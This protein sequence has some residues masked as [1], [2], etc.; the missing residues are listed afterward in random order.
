MDRYLILLIVRG[1]LPTIL[2]ISSALANPW[3][4]AVKAAKHEVKIISP[5]L[6]S[7]RL[8]RQFETNPKI[9]YQ[10]IINPDSLNN[11]R[12]IIEDLP[13]N[14]SLK[15]L[16]SPSYI[17]HSIMLVDSCKL[18]FG[19]SQPSDDDKLNFVPILIT[20]DEKIEKYEQKFDKLWNSIDKL[21]SMSALEEHRNTVKKNTVSV[22]SYQDVNQYVASRKSKIFHKLG[23]P[24]SKRIKPHNLIHFK[25]WEE[26][27]D[28]GRQP[29]KK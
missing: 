28:S 27:I 23:S 13:A 16:E 9:Q 21:K 4:R 8:I 15:I 19:G 25:S 14:V 17:P 26:A 1:L 3:M 12:L 22:S 11:P 2:L 10:I 5:G 18:L 29:A 6:Y 20:D 7:V 24:I